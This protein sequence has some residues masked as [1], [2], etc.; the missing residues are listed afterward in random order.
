MELMEFMTT[1]EQ[2]LT[3]EKKHQR[4]IRSNSTYVRFKPAMKGSNGML[5]CKT[6]PTESNPHHTVQRGATRNL[7]PR[8]TDHTE[9][10][11]TVPFIKR[12]VRGSSGAMNGASVSTI[13]LSNGT[14][15]AI[16][17]RNAAAPLF[18]FAINPVIPM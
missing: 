3:S 18:R 14:S 13:N 15:A 6:D 8:T 5:A 16:K 4:G 1:T 7:N 9:E 11:T 17:L 2:L 12:V 10:T